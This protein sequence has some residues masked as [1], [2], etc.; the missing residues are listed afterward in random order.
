MVTGQKLIEQEVREETSVGR[1]HWAASVPNAL[2]KLE[3]IAVVEGTSPNSFP[4]LPGAEP[5][6]QCGKTLR[7]VDNETYLKQLIF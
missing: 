1:T 5:E 6:F 3:N 4:F 7:I 2:W